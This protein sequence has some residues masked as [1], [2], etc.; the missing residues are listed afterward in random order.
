MKTT[1]IH[2]VYYS[3]TY[4]TRL[5]SRKLSTKIAE[6]LN[7]QLN[8][9]D[10]T[11]KPEEFAG[12]EIAQSELLV[13]AMPVYAGRIPQ[14]AVTAL[15][16]L[17]GHNTPAILICVYGNRDFDDALLEMSDLAQTNGFV[18]VSAGAFIAR[19][20]IFSNVASNRPDQE[21]IKDIELFAAKS[22]EIIKI[23]SEHPKDLEAAAKQDNRLNI[24]GNRPYKIPGSMPICPTGDD[25]C[26]NCKRCAYLCP[27]SAINPDNPTE[28]DLG[29]CI[30]CGRCI[31]ICPQQCRKFRGE[32]YQEKAA[33][34]DNA[35]G[36]RKAPTI[37]LGE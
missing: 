20:S 36:S 28:T 31:V 24:T 1:A 26:I 23:F 13:M 10:I 2:L 22:V 8:E 6:L 19:H 35:F 14:T 17:H 21:D 4:T 12:L 27:A 30:K 9:Y 33:F 15:K 34:F 3:A 11:D 5:I 25:S 16:K 7:C 32:F 18:P 37:F 29:K